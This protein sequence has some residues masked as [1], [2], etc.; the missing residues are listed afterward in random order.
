MQSFY[1]YTKYA[2]LY[3]D[4]EEKS[5]KYFRRAFDDKFRILTAS[6]AQEGFSV[7]E[8]NKDTVGLLMT[9]QQMPGEKGVQLL[10]RARHLRPRIV[11]MLVTAYSDIDAAIDAVNSGAIYKYVSK[12]WDVPQLEIT[13]RRALEFFIVQKE[14][15]SLLREKMS[16]LHNMMITDRVVSLGILAAG[17]GHHIRNALVAVRT[18]LDLAPTKLREENIDLEELRNPNYWKDFYTHVQQQVGKITEMLCD[19]GVAADKSLQSFHDRVDLPQLIERILSRLQTRFAEKKI[20]INN[21]MPGNLPALL[22]DEIKFTRLFELLFADE[23]VTL[24]EG[25]AISLRAS[26]VQEEGESQVRLEIQ[27]NGPGLPQNALRSVFDPFFLRKD[28]PQEFG[29]RLMTCFFIVYHHGGTIE[30]KSPP[31]GGTH[32]ILQFPS[33]GQSSSP[34]KDQEDFVSKVLLNETIW[35]KLLANG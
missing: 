35:E 9:D 31:G 8:Q 5:L 14:R 21:E 10:E 29:L 25:S 20:T 33:N 27:D 26:V 16:V 12:P 7:L 32:F 23:L 13:L 18:F 4:D 30:V 1:D 28:D 24:P 19:L 11:R 15:D 6:N 3:V 17:L 22:V 2:I 34:R